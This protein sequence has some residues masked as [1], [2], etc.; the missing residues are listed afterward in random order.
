VSNWREIC[1]PTHAHT[2]GKP[3]RNENAVDEGY[4]GVHTPT[5]TPTGRLHVAY[6]RRKE[7]R[8]GD[9]QGTPSPTPFFT[10]ET[11]NKKQTYKKK[12]KKMMKGRRGR[13]RQRQ[14]E[15]LVWCVCCTNKKRR[16]T[17]EDGFTAAIEQP[18]QRK[19][20]KCIKT[21]RR[22]EKRSVIDM[23]KGKRRRKSQIPKTRRGWSLRTRESEFVE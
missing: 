9:T 3:N 21:K 20:E 14:K 12:N 1:A 13:G 16:E 11:G 18:R 6:E 4:I 23:T 5:H 7:K 15:K 8:W 19:K 22:H 10:T 17:P 2:Q